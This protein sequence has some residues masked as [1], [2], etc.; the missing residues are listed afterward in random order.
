MIETQVSKTVKRWPKMKDQHNNAGFT[1]VEL[2]IVL[3][4]IGL[5]IGGILR[6]QE[7][8]ENARVSS[9]IQQVT[10]YTGAQ[11]T[12]RDAYAALPGDLATAMARV[13]G[14]TA[15]N[16]C[17]NGNGDGIVGAIIDDP[18]SVIQA[19]ITALPQVETAYFWKHMAAAHLISGVNPSAAVTSP[20]WGGA[21]P[22]AR[23]GGGFSIFYSRTV[24][25]WGT[26]HGIRLQPG[27]VTIGQQ[28]NMALSPIKASLIDRKMDDGAPDRGDVTADFAGT[29]CDAG[30]VYQVTDSKNCIMYFN[31]E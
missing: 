20:Q 28:G 7:L 11:T 15:A 30:G 13:P 12:F 19:N 27:P 26:G 21:M 8:M 24:G 1:L 25:D 16:N 3:M 10:A 31:I 9:T 18:S 5:L 4:I 29:S 2:A 17:G 14:C 23:I 22:S 6:G